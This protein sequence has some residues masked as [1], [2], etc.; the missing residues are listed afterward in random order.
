M[1]D[2]MN[3]PVRLLDFVV[4]NL[5]EHHDLCHDI[6]CH[7]CPALDTQWCHAFKDFYKARTDEDETQNEDS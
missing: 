4:R 5:R 3:D 2:A 6:W 7:G 1:R